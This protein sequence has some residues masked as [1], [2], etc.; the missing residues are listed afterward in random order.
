[1]TD[2]NYLRPIFIQSI[3]ETLFMA[4]VTLLVG[5][6]CGL[7]LGVFLYATRRGGVLANRTVNLVLNVI[8]NIV[9]PIPF[10]IFMTA[11]APLTLEVIGTTIG[12]RA[13]TFP[14]CIAAT[15]AMSRIVEQNLVTVDPGVVEAARAMG[16][17]PW[18]ILFDVVAREALGPLILGYTYVLIAIVDMTAIAGAIG[19]GGLG[20]F[21]ITYGYQRFNWTVTAVAVVTIIVLVQCAQFLGNWLARKALRR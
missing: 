16:A 8:V 18:R 10:I 9:R 5:G 17:G 6:I 1:M 13:A 19:G 21:A 12:V 7:V 15:F 2:W 14:L 4:L 3:G 20:Q 11:I